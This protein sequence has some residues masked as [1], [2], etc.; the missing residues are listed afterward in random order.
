MCCSCM[1]DIQ[2]LKIKQTQLKFVK[3]KIIMISSTFTI[4]NYLNTLIFQNIEKRFP[5]RFGIFQ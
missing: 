3:F 5:N 2:K 1:A 4:N